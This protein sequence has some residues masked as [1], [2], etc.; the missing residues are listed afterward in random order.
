LGYTAG[1]FSIW[2]GS[3]NQL[4]NGNIEFD[5]NAITTSNPSTVSEVQEVTQTSTPEII[6]KMDLQAPANAY[7]AYRIPSL[8]PGVSWQY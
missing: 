1:V 8:Y 3:I 5:A 6:W 2:G 4:P 7:R